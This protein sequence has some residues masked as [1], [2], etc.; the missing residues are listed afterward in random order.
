MVGFETPKTGAGDAHSACGGKP[1]EQEML[2]QY[3]PEKEDWTDDESQADLSLQGVSG[4]QR[5]LT[6]KEKRCDMTG[7]NPPTQGRAPWNA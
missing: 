6:V 1:S 5:T 3:D 4:A 2:L 7:A